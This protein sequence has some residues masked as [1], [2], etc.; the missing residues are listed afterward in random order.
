MKSKIGTNLKFFRKIH[1]HCDYSLPGRREFSDYLKLVY[2]VQ[3]LFVL[4]AASGK[5]KETEKKGETTN[6]SKYN[7]KI[8]KGLKSSD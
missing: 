4:K 6:A 1:N 3:G 8:E 2:A 7:R 5:A